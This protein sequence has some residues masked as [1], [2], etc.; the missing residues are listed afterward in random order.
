MDGIKNSAG[1]V[2]CSDKCGRCG[3]W[4]CNDLDGSISDCCVDSI[5]NSKHMCASVTDVGC[6]LPPAF[7]GNH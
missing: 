2:C 4:G 6:I 5:L 1:T 3:G 7:D